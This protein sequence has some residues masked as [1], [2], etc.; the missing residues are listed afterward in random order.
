MPSSKK[1]KK[2]DSKGKPIP[3]VCQFCGGNSFSP[4]TDV[5]CPSCRECFGHAFYSEL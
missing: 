3:G 2:K 4:D 5:L 1:K